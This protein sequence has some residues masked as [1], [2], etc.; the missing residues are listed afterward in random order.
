[1]LRF[2]DMYAAEYKLSVSEEHLISPITCLTQTGDSVLCG[3]GS[4]VMQ[5]HLD[6]YKATRYARVCNKNIVSTILFCR[7][8]LYIACKESSTVQVWNYNDLT[9][10]KVEI[11]CFDLIR[12]Q[13]SPVQRRDC[14]VVSMVIPDREVLW[15][16]CGNGCILLVDITNEGQGKLTLVQRH[17]TA[18]RALITSPPSPG[19]SSLV[20]SGALG[21]SHINKLGKDTGN[22]ACVFVWE[23]DLAKQKRHQECELKKR[24]ELLEN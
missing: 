22:F 3:Y 1:M 18:V 2:L 24:L 23:S 6:T 10:R 17:T 5:I 21:F 16:G 19:K 11:N 7:N 4:Y 14:R 20:I 9:K 12:Q 8:K 13:V 15:V